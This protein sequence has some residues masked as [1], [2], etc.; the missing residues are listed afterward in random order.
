MIVTDTPSHDPATFH[1]MTKTGKGRTAKITVLVSDEEKAR[2]IAA[3]DRTGEDASGFLRRLGL[4]EADRVEAQNHERTRALIAEAGL[5]GENPLNRPDPT[6]G[7]KKGGA[8]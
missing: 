4:T 6:G 1:A 5:R 2:L 8:S 3:A 7:A